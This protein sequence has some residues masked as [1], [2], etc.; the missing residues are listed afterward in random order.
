MTAQAVKR[1][2]LGRKE[3]RSVSI[4]ED[5][6]EPTAPAVMAHHS[7]EGDRSS[8]RWP[9]I[10]ALVVMYAVVIAGLI[11]IGINFFGSH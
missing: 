8:H 9:P 7:T 5:L 2:P 1:I 11:V 6:T 3:L 4:Q 10:W